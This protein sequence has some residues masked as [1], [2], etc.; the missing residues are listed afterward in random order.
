[1][2]EAARQV[3]V[4]AVV[5]RP[6]V[7]RRADEPG[8]RAGGRRR[9]GDDGHAQPRADE[10]EIGRV[11]AV[12]AYER[13]HGAPIAT[14]DRRQRVPRPYDIAPRRTGGRRRWS[15]RRKAGPQQRRLGRRACDPVGRE[16]GS[17]LEATDRALGPGAEVAVQ[18]R[19]REAVAREQEL[20][21]GDVPA[22][23]TAGQEAAAEE[24]PPEPSEGPASRRSGEAV[25][26]E[27]V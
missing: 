17:P 27:A 3:H 7:D 26:V 25:G 13:P 24:R 11:E 19:R 23:L 18:A 10:Q 21:H 14:G 4:D 12:R 1:P 15:P 20:K 16:S 8:A 9:K 5:G 22:D 6:A 2:G